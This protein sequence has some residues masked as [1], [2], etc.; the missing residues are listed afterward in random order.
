MD[1]ICLKNAETWVIL[2]VYGQVWN[3]KLF[4]KVNIFAYAKKI[5][6]NI[7][8]LNGFWHY[9]TDKAIK[10]KKIGRFWVKKGQFTLNFAKQPNIFFVPKVLRIIFYP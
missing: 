9:L 4:K 10:F 2:W 3:G 1:F 7:D 5:V 6:E 8:F